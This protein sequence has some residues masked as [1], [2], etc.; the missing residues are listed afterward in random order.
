MFAV[1]EGS[2]GIGYVST[3]ST[4]CR[5]WP[6][7][8]SGVQWSTVAKGTRVLVVDVYRA[9]HLPPISQPRPDG[10]HELELAR[11]RVE[12]YELGYGSQKKT[13]EDVHPVF[14]VPGDPKRRPAKVFGLFAWADD[15]AMVAGL[16]EYLALDRA[17]RALSDLFSSYANG[18]RREL[19]AA[20]RK[21]AADDRR[22]LLAERA[23]SVGVS[24]DELETGIDIWNKLRR[25]RF[26]VSSCL[27]CGRRLTDPGSIV[28]GIGP[29]CLRHL[30]ALRAAA[31]AKVIDIG[32]IR[33]DGDRLVERFKRAGV[34]ELARVVEEAQQQETI[35]AGRG[36]D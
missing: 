33:W 2:D 10:L 14:I 17:D 26:P 16:L 5:R 6:H 31:R 18:A 32:K 13:Y 25:K 34:E 7:N 8:I 27:C 24:V 28:S 19:E 3:N 22:R 1:S 35:S 21:R 11:T 23:E 15:R 12:R 30:P 20:K 4:L 36:Q 29:E 9:K